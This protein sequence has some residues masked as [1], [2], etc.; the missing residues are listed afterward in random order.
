MKRELDM[1][2]I[3][4][5]GMAILFGITMIYSAA[6]GSTLW[7]AQAA[8]SVLALIVAV[9]IIYVP[10]K[11]FFDL[12][13]PLYAF[14]LLTLLAVLAFGTGDPARWLS[15]TPGGGLRVQPSEFAKIMTIMALARFL[16]DRNSS[17]VA[18]PKSIVGAVAIP[19]IPMALV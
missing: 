1:G 11:L 4:A 3:V 9:A 17:H 10:D 6:S 2:L 19:V 15:L 16:G 7:R 8:Y 18:S 13:Y 14:G 12:A 5:A